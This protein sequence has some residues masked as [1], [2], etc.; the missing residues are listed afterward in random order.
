MSRPDGRESARR[1]R[2]ADGGG[3][4]CSEV[5]QQ[6]AHG[7]ECGRVERVDPCPTRLLRSHERRLSQD[8]QM[9][10]HCRPTVRLV[11]SEL[12]GGAGPL[13]ESQQEAPSRSVGECLEYVHR[14]SVTCGLH[15]ITWS[16]SRRSSRCAG[17]VLISAWESGQRATRRRR[18]LRWSAR[19]HRPRSR[20]SGAAPGRVGGCRRRCRRRIR[21]GA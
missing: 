19:G 3:R 6:F 11:R 8:S 15:I 4:P 12:A 17:P 13:R 10:T 1:A 21:C 5:L 7:T 9:A 16:S 14:G 20:R 18:R 2:G